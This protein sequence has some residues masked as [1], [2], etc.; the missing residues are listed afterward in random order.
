MIYHATID[1]HDN[2]VSIKAILARIRDDLDSIQ[3][4]VQFH[5]HR[6][7][8]LIRAQDEASRL[9][10]KKELKRAGLTVLE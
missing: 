1:S 8:I 5:I 10:A 3:I 6:D 7:G 2:G 4:N 9:M